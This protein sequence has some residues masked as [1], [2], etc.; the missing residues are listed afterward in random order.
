[1]VNCGRWLMAGTGC[2]LLGGGCIAL[3]AIEEM[4]ERRWCWFLW[5]SE[6]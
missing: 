1:M 6:W 4:F 5:V 3:S 2:A